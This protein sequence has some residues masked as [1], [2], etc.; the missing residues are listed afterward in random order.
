M[1]A[2]ETLVRL[3][4][5]STVVLGLAHG[6]GANAPPLA[7]LQ[8]LALVCA[9]LVCVHAARARGGG[10]LA[11]SALT[12][13]LTS[14]I[15]AHFWLGATIMNEDSLGLALGLCVF[16]ALMTGLAVLP[17]AALAT[18]GALAVKASSRWLAPFALALLLPL[19]ELTTGELVAFAWH[20][21]GYAWV[22]TP[23]SLALPTLGIYGVGAVV[24]LL[25]AWLALAIDDW[26]DTLPDPP[27]SA[28]ARALVLSA[29]V[30]ALLA[31]RWPNHFPDT[32]SSPPLRTRLVQTDHPLHQKFD[33]AS[34]GARVD[35][36]ISLAGDNDAE[37]IVTPETAIP[38][39]WLQLPQEL[40]VSLSAVAARPTQLFLVGMF[41]FRDDGGQLNVSSA[42][43]GNPGSLPPPRYAKRRLVPVAEYSPPGLG[44]IAD[45]LAL[46]Y[47]DRVTDESPLVAFNVGGTHVANTI[48]LDLAYSG[49]LS[50][51]AP[52]TGVIVNQS[53]FVA[54][55]GERVR[56]QFLTIA[57]ARALEQAKPVLV[58]SNSGP[59]AAIDSNGRIIARLPSHGAANL[60]VNVQPGVGSTAYATFGEILWLLALASGAGI[61]AL[62]RGRRT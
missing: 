43:R 26:W 10:I 58:A 34:L 49:E 29:V 11:L 38:V 32:A 19:A 56:Q 55:A 14:A 60:D 2:R 59:T 30:I 57:R 4:P 31:A 6:A 27:R 51:T 36:I 45:L 62:L 18:A 8:A 42:L 47:D 5:L 48:C 40:R 13:S 17:A 33:S 15:A 24:M 25:C 21:T 53:N 46:P 1:N 23:L 37:L 52:V 50:A 7:W 39:A 61:T 35:E 12:F 44:W 54:F 9:L 3:A 22:E 20:A 16:A 28:G 41:D